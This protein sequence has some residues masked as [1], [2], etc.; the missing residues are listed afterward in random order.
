MCE[1]QL[2]LG[3]NDVH[4]WYLD[5]NLY[6]DKL[7]EFKAILSQEEL[8]KAFKF[9]FEKHQNRFIITRAN[10]RL[11]LS[12][13]IN[14]APENIEFIYSEKG[15]PSLAQNYDDLGIEFNLSHSGE[16]ALYAVTKDK[17]IGIDVEKIRTNCDVES[18]AKRFF[19]ESEYQFIS[20][21]PEGEKQRV[22]YQVWTRKEAYLK[23]TG[24]GLGGGLDTI[25]LDLESKDTKIISIKGE[26]KTSNNWYLY[27]LKM[28]EN[29]LASLAVE[30]VF[31]L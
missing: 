28:P 8:T 29:Y 26:E 13:Y 21:L 24:E 18:I 22:F 23:A 2:N 25:E 30:T 6:L 11:I 15:K 1:K 31:V 14:I 19:C 10:L 17:R 4:I 27:E 9:K 3:V 16:L 12:K 20:R 7:E 5:L